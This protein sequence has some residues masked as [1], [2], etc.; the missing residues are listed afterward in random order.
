VVGLVRSPSPGPSDFVSIL[1]VEV[2][3]LFGTAA[4]ISG[5][6]GGARRGPPPLVVDFSS[7]RILLAASSSFNILS[8]HSPFSIS[9]ISRRISLYRLSSSTI[10]D[11]IRSLYREYNIFTSPGSL[12]T[13]SC[14]SRK[15]GRAGV[16]SFLFFEPESPSSFPSP[17]A[18]NSSPSNCRYSSRSDSALKRALSKVS[19]CLTRSFS[20]NNWDIFVKDVS[21]AP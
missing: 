2:E 18:F 12:S 5:A 11:I 6:L 16:G 9:S 8:S 13:W 21:W 4:G 7:C 3:S 14:A 10:A 15:V 1:G 20:V 19:S 17:S